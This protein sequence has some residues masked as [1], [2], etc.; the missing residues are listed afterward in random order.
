MNTHI[1]R[2]SLALASLALAAFCALPAQA[3]DT[4][5]PVTCVDGKTSPHGGKG[6]CSKH[7]G[8]KKDAAA[9]AVGS[10]APA[11]A[12][13]P[14]KPAAAAAPA[15][16]ATAAKPAAASATAKGSVN[17]DSTGAT[18]KCKD[19]SYSHAKQ[20]SGACSKHGGVAEWLDGSKQ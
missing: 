5:A 18:A 11:A 6:A 7:G 3:T 13:A 14:A 1:T 2:L 9:P 19:G 16:P 8:I 20:H 17:A 12:A 4:S 10:A 15:A